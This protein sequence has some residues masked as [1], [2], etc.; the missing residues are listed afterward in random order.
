[1][2]N[3]ITYNDMVVRFGTKEARKMVRT[4]EDLAQLQGEIVAPFDQ[5][6]R[7]LRALE[8]LNNVT[9]ANDV[10]SHAVS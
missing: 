6:E 1:M 10:N 2:S 5:E 9:P 4:I 8:A 3:Y 7:L